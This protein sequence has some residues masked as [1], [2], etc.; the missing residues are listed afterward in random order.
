MTLLISMKKNTVLLLLFFSCVLAVAQ[1]LKTTEIKVVEGLKVSVPDAFK[2]NTKASFSD[3]TKQDKTQKYSFIDQVYYSNF[4]TR[5]LVAAKIKSK[6]RLDFNSTS[7]RLSLGNYSF[8]S[9][10]ITY[11]SKYKKSFNYG[12]G[13]VTNNNK[14]TTEEDEYSVKN[15]SQKL[16]FFTKS[17]LAKN[18]ISSSLNYEKL[19]AQHD[20]SNTFNNDNENQF[21]YSKLLCSIKSRQAGS[22]GFSHETLLFFADLNSF[23]ENHIGLYTDIS[24]TF[25]SLPYNLS[26]EYNNYINY[27]NEETALGR[28]KKD[29]K[30]VDFTP[31]IFINKN[32]FDIDLGFN[33]GFEHNASESVID[34]F[35][36]IQISKEF[37]DDIL[38]MTF[39]IHRTDYRNTIN[40]LS[41]ENPYIHSFGLGGTKDTINYTH[42]LQTTDIYESYFNL[43][44]KLSKNETLDF[45]IGYG[46][47][48][49]FHYYD[50]LPIAGYNRFGVNY[51]DVWQ[52]RVNGEYNR[53]FNNILSMNL[54]IDYYN[55]FDVVVPHKANLIGCFK[56]PFKLRNKI[57]ITPSL[58]YIGKRE[59]N[60]MSLN[61]IYPPE[62]NLI[63][64]DEQYLINL[65]VSYN[66]S[67]SIGFYIDF[68]NLSN[69][70]KQLW[71]GYQQLGLNM[72]FGLNCLF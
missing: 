69:S 24:N 68:N 41:R 5:S 12:L 34:V 8:K 18:I 63:Q 17:I 30:I 31:S 51:I 20:F 37:V 47:V 62:F 2:L 36:K 27:S 71:N 54:N 23:T 11:N 44:N 57:K 1:D 10:S 45:E 64:L 4:V 16:Y 58:D 15:N 59:A 53:K 67:K 61:L 35:P 14:Y 46:K 29:V 6:A 56:I 52:L 25:N 22:K 48:L 40:S 72:V 9:A 3:T 50:L 49:N 38:S 32:D 66:Y 70:K 19:V 42:D 7:I 65:S 55:W 43:S 33:L 26:I 21:T 39:G 13:L 28:D 60:Q